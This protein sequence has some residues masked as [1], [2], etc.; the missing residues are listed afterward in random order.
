[1]EWGAE[2]MNDAE[3]LSAP[4]RKN[5]ILF[6]EKGGIHDSKKDLKSSQSAR[7]Y[8]KFCLY[9]ASILKKWFYKTSQITNNYCCIFFW[10]WL[11][12]DAFYPNCELKFLHSNVTNDIK[13]GRLSR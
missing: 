3:T 2:T 9:R 12:L 13:E 11:L 1:M 5:A 4:V 7:H 10:L 8:R 6:G